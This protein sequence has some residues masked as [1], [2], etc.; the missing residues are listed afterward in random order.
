MS[1]QHTDERPFGPQPEGE[2]QG[3][4]TATKTSVGNVG[5]DRPKR[6]AT[7]YKIQ[8]REPAALGHPEAWTDVT[9]IVA[10]NAKKAIQDWAEA[11]TPAELASD[12]LRVTVRAIPVSR[13]TQV[14]IAV[15]QRSTLTFS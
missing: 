7:R 11:Q 8:R 15:E 12:E 6:Q 2:A 5:N 3:G 9:V 14:D 13:I 1:L 10:H 4:T